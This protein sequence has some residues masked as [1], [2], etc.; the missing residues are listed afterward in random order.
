MPKP[1]AKELGEK[2]ASVPEKR[3]AVPMRATDCGAMIECEIGE[4]ALITGME[5]NK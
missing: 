5:M 3:P 4:I 1:R 2:T